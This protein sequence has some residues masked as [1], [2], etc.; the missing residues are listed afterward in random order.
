MDV[1]G[2]S[3]GTVGSNREEWNI[4]RRRDARAMMDICVLT[5]AAF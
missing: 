3:A 1:M 5:N 4:G 2:K